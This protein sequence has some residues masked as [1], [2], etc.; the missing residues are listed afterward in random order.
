MYELEDIRKSAEKL[1][2]GIMRF[3]KHGGSNEKKYLI[4]LSEPSEIQT[5]MKAIKVIDDPESEK[6]ILN[7][8]PSS[9]DAMLTELM[10]EDV[11]GEENKKEIICI[12]SINPDAFVRVNVP[13]DAKNVS[14]LVDQM[15]EDKAK[16]AITFNYNFINYRINLDPK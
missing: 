5:L 9:S 15:G 12:S 6:Q 14:W 3:Q 10:Y 16:G 2:E 4:N 11:I 7:Y 8:P 1:P 13:K